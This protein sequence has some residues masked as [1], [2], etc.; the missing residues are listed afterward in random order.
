MAEKTAKYL[1]AFE[2]LLAL[3]EIVY[4]MTERKEML[5]ETVPIEKNIFSIFVLHTDI[6][7]KEK[8]RGLLLA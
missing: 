4:S 6:L 5:K 8:T 1:E 3:M 2:V 7:V